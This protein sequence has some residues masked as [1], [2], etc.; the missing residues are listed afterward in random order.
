MTR[1]SPTAAGKSSS[2]AFRRAR[3]RGGEMEN[4]WKHPAVLATEAEAIDAKHDLEDLKPAPPVH[5]SLASRQRR[6]ERRRSSEEP[7][8]GRPRRR[9]RRDGDAAEHQKN[10]AGHPA[11]ATPPKD[12]LSTTPGRGSGDSPPS[13]RRSDR[14]RVRN[15]TV[16]PAVAVGAEVALESS[17]DTVERG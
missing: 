14:R 17:L 1:S 6:R 2:S 16:A 12:P 4:H 11:E 5:P 7:A 10:D 3:G 15:P 13:S 8:A 9:R